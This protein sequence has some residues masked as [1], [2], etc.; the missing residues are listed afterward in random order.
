MTE[1]ARQYAPATARNR[2][3]IW[4]VLQRHLPASG[5]VLEVA[6][7]S[8]EH[9]VHFARASGPQI[10][11]QPSDA[12]A[13]ARASID[14][15][16]A[17]S[18]LPNIRPALALDATA[19]PWPIA[20]AD[21]VLC[22]NMIHIAPW[23]AASSRQRRGARAPAGRHPVLYGPFKREGRHTA[24]SNEAFDRDFLRARNPP[25]AC[26]TWR[27]SPRSRRK[28]A[29][30]R[31]WSS[32]CRPTICRSCF[33]GRTN[34]RF[35]RRAYPHPIPPRTKGSISRRP[36][37]R[38][39]CRSGTRIVTRGATIRGSPHPPGESPGAGFR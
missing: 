6:S 12:D 21:V 38:A 10:V 9:A 29:S 5:L 28:R 25:G 14:A 35:Y 31:L 22:C 19:Q 4:S 16:T 7:G 20:G 26:A 8:G 13:A 18:G 2:D 15:W 34:P 33:G 36:A 32:P 1:D 3:P 39:G 30:R 23:E 37:S 17:A 27:P 11:F 24:P